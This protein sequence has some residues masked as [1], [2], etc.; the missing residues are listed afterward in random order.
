MSGWKAYTRSAAGLVML[1]LTVSVAGA[2]EE[3]APRLKYRS[4][5]PVCSCSSGL[6]EAEI[7]RA[8]KG[9]DRLQSAEPGDRAGTTK[10]SE[11]QTRRETDEERK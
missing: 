7:S 3:V 4:K 6:G 10:G 2:A 1:A 5:G 11:Q 9:L 8:M